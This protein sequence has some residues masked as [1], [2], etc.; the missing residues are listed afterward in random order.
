MLELPNLWLVNAY[1][2]NSSE[3]PYRDPFT[4][5][6]RGS[7]SERKREFQRL[8]RAELDSLERPPTQ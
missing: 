2:P 5:E 7:R 6:L 3:Y 1:C 8:L 4:G